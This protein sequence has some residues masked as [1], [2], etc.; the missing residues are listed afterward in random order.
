MANTSSPD[1]GYLVVGHG[2][3]DPAGQAE[4]RE[5][6]RQLAERISSPVAGGFLELAEPTIARGLAEL[7]KRGVRRVFVVPLLLF[8]AGHAKED[9]PSAVAEAARE[10][11][12]EVVGQS[13]ALEL[14]P[15][16]LELSRLRFWEKA[17]GADCDLSS[18][19]LLLIGRGG[20]DAKALEAMRRY[21]ATFAASLGV[22]A[23][24]AFAAVAR[25]TVEE[26]MNELSKCGAAQVVVQP[27]LLFAGEVSQ[28][29]NRQVAAAREAYPR[30]PWLIARHLGPHPLLIESILANLQQI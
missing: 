29:I 23:E 8:T 5:V 10:L 28:A 27:H 22:T 9:V 21:A 12:I 30:V 11:A 20:S 25:P 24:T 7:R 2:T 16:L 3:R 13:P 18:T 19:R 6:V 15:K 4:F 26:A 14:H 17:V 1:L